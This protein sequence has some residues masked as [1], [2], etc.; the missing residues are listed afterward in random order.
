MKLE[1]PLADT[2]H[3][4]KIAGLN[5]PPSVRTGQG[6]DGEAQFCRVDGA[7]K[8]RVE[9]WLSR[10]RLAHRPTFIP[11]SMAAKNLSPDSLNPKLGSLVDATLPQHRWNTSDQGWVPT[12]DQYPVW[13]FSMVSIPVHTPSIPT[14]EI[15]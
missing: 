15:R 7:A 14:D 4:Q 2:K 10:Q 13:T 3:L 6:E 8:A 11:E 9:D 1:D 5:S 12:Q